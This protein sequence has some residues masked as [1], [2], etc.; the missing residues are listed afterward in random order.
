VQ[1]SSVDAQFSTVD[2]LVVVPVP[3]VQ[4]IH[5]G[6]LRMALDAVPC[7]PLASSLAD[8]QE[9]VGA[10]ALEPRVPALELVRAL[11]DRLVPAR[12]QVA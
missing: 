3:V 2:A 10:R 4:D 9:Q 7:T 6:R 12:V 5:P 1:P 8:L 11:E